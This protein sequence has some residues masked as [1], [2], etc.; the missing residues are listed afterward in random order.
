MAIEKKVARAKNVANQR[1]TTSADDLFLAALERGGDIAKT[2][3]YLMTFKEGAV[4]AGSRFLQSEH[5]LR[6]ANARDFT[7]QAVSF[8]QA[9]DAEALLF[10]EIGVALIG[11]E[12]VT[13]RGMRTEAFIAE[14]SPVH[15]IDPEFFMFATQI[16]S[17]DY[18]RGMLRAVET[19]YADLGE[20]QQS[21]LTAPDEV[22]PQALGVTWGLAA[23]KVPS[24]NFDAN[25]IKVVV[26]DPALIWATPSLRA[27]HLSPKL[28]SDSPSRTSTAM[29]PTPRARLAGPRLPRER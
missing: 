15:S 22:S 10:P 24:S 5:G 1:I 25:D 2:G 16:N 11:G 7:D 13:E 23:R 27:G 26:L 20:P 21:E 12:A 9:G 14:D 18:L 8:E 28:S 3:R 19:I 17:S 29:E 4:D 6:V